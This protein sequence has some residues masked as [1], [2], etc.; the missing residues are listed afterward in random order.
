[1]ESGL[2][3]GIKELVDE[4]NNHIDMAADLGLSVKVKQRQDKYE[5]SENGR[6]EPISN[7]TCKIWREY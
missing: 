4:L 2:I 3:A 5:I 1:M 7:V 6:I